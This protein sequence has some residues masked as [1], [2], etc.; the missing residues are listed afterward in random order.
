MTH[1]FA[2]HLSEP[3]K[4]IVRPLVKP[5]RTPPAAPAPAPEPVPEPAPEVLLEAKPGE[6]SEEYWTRVNVTSH[7]QFASAEESLASFYWR[8]LQYLNYIEFM[9]VAGYDGKVILDYG[10]GPG[11]DLIGFAH[12]SKP[13]RLIAM[14]V[15]STSLAEAEHRLS[16]HGGRAE[17]LRIREDDPT[18]PL[19][20]ASIDVI[21]SSG[22]LH[23]APDPDKI[24]T[25]LCRV[26]RPDGHA[27]IMIYNYE[28][29]LVHLYTAYVVRMIEKR[30]I[31][32]DLRATFARLTDGPETPISNCY[33]SEEFSSLCQGAGFEVEYLGGAV[34]CLEMQ[35]LPKRFD[36]LLDR[37][38]P[39][40]SR[41]F[42]YDL[43]FDDRGLPRIHGRLAGVDGCYRLRRR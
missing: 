13:S 10:C 9:P 39:Q 25:E 31:D 1:K 35:M 22:V 12:F 42:L 19:D 6:T 28:S 15:S 21:H 7:H 34:S 36:A 23:H 17:F 20:D 3:F 2:S 18:L 30:Y 32:R 16:L 27:Q 5:F 38:L 33:S 11:H 24:L 4:A 14:D 8:T 40:E 41:Q 26:L 37:E 43:R 29:V